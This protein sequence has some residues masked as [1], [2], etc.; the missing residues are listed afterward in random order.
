MLD[1]GDAQLTKLQVEVSNN[2]VNA[3]SLGGIQQGDSPGWRLHARA[4]ERA[5]EG[6]T[7]AGDS[8][9]IIFIISS[10]CVFGSLPLH[11]P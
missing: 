6:K 9:V 8:D 4:A 10:C 2:D 7:G 3:V 1:V 11:P 5:F